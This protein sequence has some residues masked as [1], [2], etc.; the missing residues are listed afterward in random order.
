M[1]RALT[2]GVNSLF[3]F[4]KEHKCRASFLTADNPFS[5]QDGCLYS[6]Q[7]LLWMGIR[8]KNLLVM[9]ENRQKTCPLENWRQWL[10][11]AVF[12]PLE[13]DCVLFFLR[14]GVLKAE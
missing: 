11:L 14:D 3:S 5:W 13:T 1:R 7:N 10:N 8:M 4:C 6:G 2:I 12:F 9:E